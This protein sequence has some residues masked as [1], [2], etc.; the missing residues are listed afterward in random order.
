MAQDLKI[1][2]VANEAFFPV[3]GL[4]VA[5]AAETLL[6]SIANLISTRLGSNFF[7]PESGIDWGKMQYS[8]GEGLEVIRAEIAQTITALERSILREQEQLT[9]QIRESN[10]TFK[11]N[12]YGQLR[13]LKIRQIRQLPQL[14]AVEVIIDIETEAKQIHTLR[15]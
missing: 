12:P 2:T 15:L 6:Q 14:D 1:F 13:S 9:E 7:V 5:S 8:S 4:S 11:P 3:E 10:P